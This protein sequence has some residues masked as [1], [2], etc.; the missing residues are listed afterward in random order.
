MIPNFQSYVSASSPCF[1]I[2]LPR[3]WSSPFCSLVY[4]S[5]FSYDQQASLGFPTEQLHRQ[6][7]EACKISPSISLELARFNS[8][9]YFGQSKSQAYLRSKKKET[10][11]HYWMEEAAKPYC[12]ACD[13]INSEEVE[14][15]LQLL[16]QISLQLFQICL[17]YN[18]FF[19][20]VFTPMQTNGPY[21]LTTEKEPD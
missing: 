7:A 9:T 21:W 2:M 20:S 18:S 11:F 15:I 10:R 5:C 3:G 14:T 13:T 8:T 12:Q 1:P 4:R 19:F 17:F 16:N 6:Q